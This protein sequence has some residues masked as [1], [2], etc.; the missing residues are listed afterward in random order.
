M[1]NTDYLSLYTKTHRPPNASYQVFKAWA[2]SRQITKHIKNS[3]EL[4]RLIKGAKKY[5]RYDLKLDAWKIP[6][7]DH[8]SI[9]ENVNGQRIVCSHSYAEPEESL[10]YLSEEMKKYGYGVSVSNEYSWY[11]PDN[12][13]LIEIKI[14]IPIKQLQDIFPRKNSRRY[15]R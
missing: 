3:S 12:T 14:D 1:D 8:C 4:F 7:K 11:Y 10:N 13:I 5:G 15:L 2:E 9:W 6:Y